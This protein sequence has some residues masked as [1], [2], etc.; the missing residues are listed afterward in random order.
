MLFY[1]YTVKNS[2]KF[3]HI[4]LKII[5]YFNVKMYLPQKLGNFSKISSNL[6][7]MKGK[8]F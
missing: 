6:L 1:L 5:V 2:G 4:L 7:L 3:P 8:I